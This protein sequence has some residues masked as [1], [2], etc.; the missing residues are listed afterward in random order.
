MLSEEKTVPA[1]IKHAYMYIHAY[2][3]VTGFSCGVPSQDCFRV[4]SGDV[5]AQTM[6]L[7]L[8]ENNNTC[9][10]MQCNLGTTYI[11]LSF[12]VLD[13]LTNESQGWWNE[14]KNC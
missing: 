1:Y 6:K 2:F 11:Q 8:N 13:N 10:M 14:K 5:W 12:L 9:Y 7:L 4:G 3:I